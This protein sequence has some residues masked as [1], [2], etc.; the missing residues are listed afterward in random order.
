M[1]PSAQGPTPGIKARP[2]LP[3]MSI[4]SRNRQDLG[5]LDLIEETKDPSRIYRWVR[6]RADENMTSVARSKFH[7]YSVEYQKEGGVRTVAEIDS[8]PDK[9]IVIGDLILMSRSLVDHQNDQ[10][11]QFRRRE[12]VL[13]S[14]SAE[15]EEMAKDKGISIIKD[16]DHNSKGSSE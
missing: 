1:S 11:D 12:A 6:C 15:T 8:R 4:K 16:T 14:L 7:G 13:N 2:P 3:N 9:A 10:D 5:L